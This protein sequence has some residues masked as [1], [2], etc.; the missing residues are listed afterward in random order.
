M[1]ESAD[2]FDGERTVKGGKHKITIQADAFCINDG[3]QVVD[4]GKNNIRVE[5]ARLAIIQRDG[6]RQ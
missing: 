6:Q 3:Q 5:C 4:V 2:I 1:A